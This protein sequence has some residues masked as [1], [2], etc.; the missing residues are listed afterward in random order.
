MLVV[1]SPAALLKTINKV[2]LLEA[3]SYR[4]IFSLTTA[5][6]WL[7]ISFYDLMTFNYFPIQLIRCAPLM[8]K[9]KRLTAT[10][11]Y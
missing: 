10:F 3:S 5:C 8:N 9:T 7:L 11:F 1:G 6:T 2:S 4:Q